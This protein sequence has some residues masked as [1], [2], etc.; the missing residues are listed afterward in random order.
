MKLSLKFILAVIFFLQL[1]S[2][3]SVAKK[4]SAEKG[5]DAKKK[6]ILKKVDGDEEG[7][8]EK[9]VESHPEPYFSFSQYLWISLKNSSSRTGFSR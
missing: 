3:G 1:T 2:C 5:R 9:I 8:Y 7:A 6:P 4:Y